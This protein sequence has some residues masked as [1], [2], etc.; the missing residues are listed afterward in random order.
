MA[1]D[2]LL[3]A[4]KV[5]YGLLALDPSAASVRAIVVD[6]VVEDK[7]VEAA[8]PRYVIVLSKRGAVLRLHRS[9]GCSG[10]EALTFASYKLCDLHPVPSALY[11]HYCHACWPGAA[12]ATEVQDEVQ[13]WS[14]D[15]STESDTSTES[16]ISACS[17]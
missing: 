2:R 8:H 3:V 5:F 1:A 11:T 14:G 15:M 6:P 12:P 4:A 9:D 16:S 10:A 7:V 17:E 13:E